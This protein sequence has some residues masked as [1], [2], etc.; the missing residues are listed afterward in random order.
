MNQG[1]L[2]LRAAARE[3]TRIGH[4]KEEIDHMDMG[5]E[6]FPGCIE[7]ALEAFAGVAIFRMRMQP[8]V[9]FGRFINKALHA[10]LVR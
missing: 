10:M 1:G 8:V 3:E 7:A 5:G 6:N 4:A 2:L 9:L